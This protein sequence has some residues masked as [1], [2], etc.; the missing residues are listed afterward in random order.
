MPSLFIPPAPNGVQ[1]SLDSLR[2]GTVLNE[3]PRHRHNAERARPAP[4][5]SR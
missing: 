1:F 2:D 5:P 3:L 4:L